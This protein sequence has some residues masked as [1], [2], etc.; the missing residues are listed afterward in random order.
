[1]TPRAQVHLYTPAPGRPLAGLVRSILRD[2]SADERD[3]VYEWLRAHGVITAAQ[4]SPG[5]FIAQCDGEVV[6]RYACG[7]VDRTKALFDLLHPQ[8][9]EAGMEAA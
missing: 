7:D 4:K 5:A 1:M 8:V 9:V 2:G 3:E 6:G